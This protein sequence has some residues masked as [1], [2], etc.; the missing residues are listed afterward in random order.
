MNHNAP[1]GLSW[2]SDLEA[3]QRQLLDLRHAEH[4]W[5]PVHYAA[6]WVLTGVRD[7]RNETVREVAI[8]MKQ[9]D[10]FRY[11]A[12]DLPTLCDRVA[13]AMEILRGP[14]PARALHNIASLET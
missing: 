8:R 11:M 10:R 14:N 3:A 2:S 6:D 13:R 12:L 4:P 1:I 9:G 5:G 7:G